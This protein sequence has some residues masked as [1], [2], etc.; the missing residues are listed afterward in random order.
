MDK[1]S[2]VLAALREEQRRLAEELAGV[3]RTI[4][5]LEKAVSGESSAATERGA[6]QAAATLA[7]GPY[8]TLGL[9]QATADYLS[10]A[11]T[12]KTTREIAD[13][14]RAGG[15]PTSSQNFTS[16]VGTM[17][18]RRESAGAY[19]IRRT[20]DGKRWFVRG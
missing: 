2:E 16:T 4:A 15:Y 13:A 10:A 6:G 14:L 18:R 12:P 1:I 5:V 19:G 20:Q 7:I 17:L 8:V 3:E 11:G 9:Y